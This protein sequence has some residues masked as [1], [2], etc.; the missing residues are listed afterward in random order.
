VKDLTI[1]MSSPKKQQQ[2]NSQGLLVTKSIYNAW[3]FSVLLLL[4]EAT[5]WPD[6]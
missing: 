6:I 5:P 1:Y 4:L 3:M 2:T